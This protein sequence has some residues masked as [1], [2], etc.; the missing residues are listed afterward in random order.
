MNASIRL[1]GNR[2]R[3][4]AAAALLALAG[5]GGG[6]GDG[7]GGIDPA[8]ARD[9]TGAEPPAETPADQSARA[10]GI[11][12]R[13]DS[14][15]LST[16]HEDTGSRAPLEFQFRADGDE[17]RARSYEV[18]TECAGAQCNWTPP[19][20]AAAIETPLRYLA[21]LPGA[22]AAILTKSGISLVEGRGSAAPVI[23]VARVAPVSGTAEGAWAESL[24][25]W[26]DHGWF[27]VQQEGA[28]VGNYDVTA[29]YAIAGGDLTGSLP[30]ASATWT[31]LMVGAPRG[32]DFS[33]SVLQGDAKL[34]LTFAGNDPRLGAAFSNI[35]DLRKGTAYAASEA[36]FDGIAL[37][38]TVAGA[39]DGTFRAG[40]AGNRIQGGFYGPNHAETAGIFEQAG[41][42]GAFGAKRDPAVP[43]STVFVSTIH[44]ATNALKFPGFEVLPV[45]SG[46]SCRWRIPGTAVDEAVGLEHLDI[47]PD[48]AG[49]TESFARHG[50]EIYKG[51]G[52]P[53][54]GTEGDME[55]EYYIAGTETGMEHASFALAQGMWN[56]ADNVEIIGR[57]GIAGGN[58]LSGVPPR[59]PGIS[60]RW[61]GLMVGAP[62]DGGYGGNVLV[63]NAALT[64]NYSDTGPTLDA[65]FSGI[66]NIEQGKAHSPSSMRF[67]DVPVAQDGSY[68][69]GGLGNRIH[70]GFFGPGH[71]EAAGAFEQQGIVAAFGAKRERGVFVTAIQ[72]EPFP[73]T[74]VLPV[75]LDTQC[76]WRM[77]DSGISGIVAREHLEV[78]PASP[79]EPA[80]PP[81]G[82]GIVRGNGELDDAM[83]E[84]YRARMDSASFSLAQATWSGAG[85]A[86]VTGRFGIAGGD[87]T[88]TSPGNISASWSGLMVGAP[89]DGAFHDNV[90]IGNADLAYTYSDTGGTVDAAF[91]NIENARQGAAHSTPSVRFDDV[92]VAPDGSYR[93]GVLGNR[94]HGGLF[95]P[96]H[97][98]AAGVFEGSGIV[99]AFGAQPAPTIFV[100][101]IHGGMFPDTGVLP[102]CIDT[103]CRWRPP[104][105][106]GF[107]SFAL[108][109]LNIEPGSSEETRV[110]GKGGIEI[111]KGRGKAGDDDIEYYRARMSGVSFSLAQAMWDRAGDD[112]PTG[113]FG[114]AGAER[115]TGA[116]P[117]KQPM[118]ASWSGLMVGAPK[119]GAFHD[120]VLVGDAE[121]TY[122]YSDTGGT[123]AAAFSNIKDLERRMAHSTPSMRFDDV[124][125]L[126]D[127]SYR[128]GKIGD[129][130]HGGFFGPGHD[131]TAGVF[132]KEGIVGAFGAKRGE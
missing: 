7:G 112:D 67:D 15:I 9:L 58:R 84:Y 126:P 63:G 30:R 45:C 33:D 73:D 4:A 69:K 94:I 28:Q 32:G 78:A 26:M 89:K 14:L 88:G 85:E 129:R 48:A 49:E 82:I 12:S 25:A 42:T 29:R 35:V 52:A 57:F 87:A 39:Y 98:E 19:G 65:E 118:S 106:G 116:P 50:I 40:A 71:A 100:T 44:G 121:L 105:G 54:R 122:T 18:T 38:R 108:R 95:G 115:L 62:K 70:G 93:K 76:R 64:Y 119:D 24:G 56:R 99:G 74:G 21:F 31:G 5:C 103:E 127:G 59:S 107:V 110:F 61:S 41:I 120:N 6:G 23:D 113:R 92:P 123:V 132:E 8:A 80:V 46:A 117:G 10:A 128:K 79:E 3:L 101:S 1:A 104:N 97:E 68:R 90:L 86:D 51:R 43:A 11:L 17:A 75:C 91:S 37:T 114:A 53:R 55:I 81:G 111:A 66:E 36:R 130:I 34:T 16:I 20:T 109:H 60:A 102:L 22:A 2:R 125:V 96:N 77:P 124:P 72:G 47:A 131:E 83:V 13:A 27:A